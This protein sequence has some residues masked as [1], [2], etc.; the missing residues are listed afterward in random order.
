MHS[1][2]A[3]S[4]GA[5]VDVQASPVPKRT[6][7]LLVHGARHS[8][9][10]FQRLTGD[11]LKL[12][13]AAF[14]VDLLGHG[15]DARLPKSYQLQPLDEVGFHSEPS[16]LAALT[17]D[18]YAARVHRAVDQLHAA[19]FEHVALLG[20]SLGGATLTKVA[21]AAPDKVACLIY[22]AAFMLS[23]G[24]SVAQDASLDAGRESLV[25]TLVRADPAKVGAWGINFQSSAQDYLAR[26]RATFFQDVSE[27]E[28]LSIRAGR[29]RANLD[30]GGAGIPAMGE[31]AAALCAM[32]S[33]SRHSA[34]VAGHAGGSSRRYE[35]G[36]S[37]MSSSSKHEPLAIAPRG[38]AG[39]PHLGRHG[40]PLTLMGHIAKCSHDPVATG[41]NCNAIG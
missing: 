10:C 1:L 35:S 27:E 11:L 25:R 5:V 3:A 26:V 29:A 23:G 6:A 18:D 8:A 21:E 16:P 12:G 39:G 31:R 15:L 20:H 40:P 33:G 30:S 22:L 36:Q 13:H 41:P 19:G 34:S 17:L 32:R 9:W 38:A 7:F 37:N 28:F 24:Q 4:V 2:A 14:A